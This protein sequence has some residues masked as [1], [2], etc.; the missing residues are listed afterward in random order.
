MTRLDP[1]KHRVDRYDEWFEINQHAYRSELQAMRSLLPQKGDR[2]E[3]GVGTGR[4]AA[5]LGVA[6]GLDPSRAMMAE[7]RR[8][9]VTVVEGIAESLPFKDARFDQVLM[10]TVVFLLEN[11]DAAF[12][13]ARRVLKP[14]G[15]LVVGFIDKNSDLGAVY[16]RRG[17]EST[18]YGGARLLSSEDMST[19]LKGAGFQDLAFVQTLFRLPEDLDAE[20]PVE[21]GYGRGSFVVVRGQR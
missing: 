6:L 3:V 9:R 17:D 13:E 11:P 8:R 7:A 14:G 21:A 4:F 16:E 15:A 5:P 20:D 19:L 12:R 1:Y 18:F 2:L 10:V